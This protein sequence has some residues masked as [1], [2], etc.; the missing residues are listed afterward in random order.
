MG[1]LTVGAGGE[2]LAAKLVAAEHQL[3]GSDDLGA[4]HGRAS[5][6]VYQVDVT[7]SQGCQLGAQ[8]E[9]CNRLQR[10]LGL[11]AKVDIAVGTFVGGAEGAESIDGNQRRQPCAQY[12]QQRGQSR[13]CVAMMHGG[14]VAQAGIRVELIDGSRNY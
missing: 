2:G 6:H 12:V 11:Q 5:N 1:V 14:N 9:Q 8:V 4:H 10:V 13:L 3:A 7:T